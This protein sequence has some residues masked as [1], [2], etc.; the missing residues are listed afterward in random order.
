MADERWPR[1]PECGG[2][3]EMIA[4]EGRTREIERG[5]H[6]AI[7]SDVKIPTCTLCGEE[8]MSLD[9]SEPLDEAL[10]TP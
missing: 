3:V 4:R 2:D 5:I 7:P 6:V 9:V 10:R 1:C 8:M